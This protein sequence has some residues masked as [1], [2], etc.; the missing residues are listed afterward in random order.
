MTMK[1]P[2]KIHQALEPTKPAFANKT[3]GIMGINAQAARK[4][5]AETWAKFN[6]HPAHLG[7]WE[8]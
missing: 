4:P 3:A 2:M 7:F 6:V 1:A 5:H 8:R